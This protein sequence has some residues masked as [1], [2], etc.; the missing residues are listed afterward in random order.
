M[1]L[2][3]FKYPFVDIFKFFLRFNMTFEMVAFLVSTKG[4]LK[5]SDECNRWVFI[6]SFG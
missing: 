5:I 6:L 3:K 4:L 1:R 2:Q